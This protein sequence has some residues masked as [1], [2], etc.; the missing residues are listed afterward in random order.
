MSTIAGMS[1]GCTSSTLTTCSVDLGW[2]VNDHLRD[3]VVTQFGR[4]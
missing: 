1:S 4:K 2:M 3:T